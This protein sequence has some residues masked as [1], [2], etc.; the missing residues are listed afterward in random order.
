MKHDGALQEDER[1]YVQLAVLYTDVQQRRV[2]R[3]HNLSMRASSNHTSIFRS[4][5]LDA[6]SYTMMARG[7][8]RAMTVPISVPDSNSPR[9]LVRSQTAEMLASYRLHC[10]SHS[11]VVSLTLKP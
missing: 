6:I 9:E 2:V 8:E 5:D 1:M 3:V 7:I 11:P 10:S 4:C